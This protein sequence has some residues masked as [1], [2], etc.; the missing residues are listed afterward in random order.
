[1]S[2]IR[3]KMGKCWNSVNLPLDPLNL[4]SRGPPSLKTWF[5]HYLPH[6]P[7]SLHH[8]KKFQ[9]FR[10]SFDPPLRK[11]SISMHESLQ[12]GQ[13]MDV[14]KSD[15]L[16]LRSSANPITATVICKWCKNPNAIAKHS[17]FPQWKGSIG[18]EEVC[19]YRTNKENKKIHSVLS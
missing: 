17:G 16:W 3:S 18:C 6:R 10:A 15:E 9:H 7:Q 11:N 12:K 4:P 13:K 5:T 8:E 14:Y 1:M 19:D 2:S